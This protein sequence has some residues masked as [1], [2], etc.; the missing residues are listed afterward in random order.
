M[1]VSGTAF[2]LV[3][4]SQCPKL[5]I[6]CFPYENRA[7]CELKEATTSNQQARFR[8]ISSLSSIIAF[9][10]GP[11]P[12]PQGVTNVTWSAS[13][14]KID[15]PMIGHTYL[16]TTEFAGQQIIVKATITGA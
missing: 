2:Y 9:Q 10:A 12:L 8:P 14:G 1:V 5:E 13:A 15:N 7:L 4:R 16:D 11:P 6:V 3:R